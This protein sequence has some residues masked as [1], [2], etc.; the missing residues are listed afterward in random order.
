MRPGQRRDVPV[1]GE[2]DVRS[3]QSDWYYLG[4]ALLLLAT[5]ATSRRREI[6]DLLEGGVDTEVKIKLGAWAILGLVALWRL[7]VILRN[8]QLLF[9]FPVA[10]YVAFCVLA[11]AAAPFS[12]Q[13][14]LSGIK[15]AQLLIV[16]ALGLSM[17]DRIN[18]WPK[19]AAIYLGINWVFLLIGLTGLVPGLHWRDLPGFQEAGY[20]GVTGAWR[21]GTPIGHFLIISY[22]AA[23]LAVALVA[24]MGG[25]LTLGGTVML[26][27][28]VATLLLTVSRTGLVGT[29]LGVGVL[30]LL[31]G[32]LPVAVLVLGAFGSLAL[33]VPGLSNAIED[34]LTRG[35]SG[36]ELASL[37]GRTGVYESALDLIGDKWLT[38]YGFRASRAVRL[39]EIQDHAG[40]VFTVAAHAHNAVLESAASLGLAGAACAVA[41]LLSFLFCAVALLG[42]AAPQSDAADGVPDDRSRAV[43]YCAYWPPILVFSMVDSSFALEINP[44]ILILI[45]ILLDFARHRAQRRDA[46]ASSFS[47]RRAIDGVP[48][49]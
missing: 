4:P 10:P 46:V 29:V 39:E 36:E 19:L 44:F 20:D 37:T 18:E 25:R 43:E 17:I 15:S 49:P 16:I 47:S 26:L 1:A 23:M 13:P 32:A 30:L 28:V 27:W 2:H 5:L 8:S 6:S 48:Q 35:Q 22:V 12:L 9:V 11:L 41:L 45:V 21:F 33:I 34:F 7:P 31:R 42:R 3:R 24:R 38:G 14:A 40:N